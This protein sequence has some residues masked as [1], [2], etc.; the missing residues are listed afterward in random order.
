MRPTLRRSWVERGVL[1]LGVIGTTIAL[2]AA[3]V[4]NL[5]RVKLEAITEVPIASIEEAKNGE[6][7]NWLLVGSDSREGIDENDPR[8]GIFLGDETPGGKRTDTMMIARVDPELGTIDLLSIPRD[9]YVP[10][11]GTDRMGRVNTAFN[12]EGGEERLVNTIEAY[13]D[14]EINHYA[15]I[16]FVGFQ[17]I[18]DALGGVPIWFDYPMRDPGSALDVASAGCQVLDGF[19]ALAFARGRKLE[20]FVD[21]EWRFDP[22]GDLGRTS[23]QQYFVRRVAATATRK[24]DFT[25]LGTVNRLLDAGSQNLTISGV[26][27]GDLVS[28]ARIFSAVEADQIIGH[29]L[30]VF[31]FRTEAGA[32]VLGLETEQAQAI[33]DIFRGVD[34]AVSAEPTTTTTIRNYTVMVL[35]GSRVSGQAGDTTKS[36]AAAGFSMSVAGN[37]D[38]TE[39]TTVAYGPGLEEAAIDVAR[40]LGVNPVVRFDASLSEVVVTTGADFVGVL[41]TPRSKASVYVPTTTT[42]PTTTAP[43]VAPQPTVGFVPGPSPEGTLCE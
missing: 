1:S 2:V 20:Y 18:V 27:I 22:T 7:A 43:P 25:S 30:P 5:G 16:N 14:L 28:L 13:F 33:L 42:P 32:A 24:L 38:P 35:N 34:P 10:I 8:S 23:R 19:D 17:D 11:A 6:P 3:G 9:L 37:A 29:S 4:L 39:K 40:W 21:G 12:G 31:D 26:E 36:L 15:E 41:D